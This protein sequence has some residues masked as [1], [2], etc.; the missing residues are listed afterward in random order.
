[1]KELR[2]GVFLEPNTYWDGGE[3][4]AFVGLTLT[5]TALIVFV[6]RQV[7]IWIKILTDPMSHVREAEPIECGVLDVVPEQSYD[8]EPARVT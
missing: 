3:Y 1:M 5:L 2:N 6:I 4:L 8:L 7:K